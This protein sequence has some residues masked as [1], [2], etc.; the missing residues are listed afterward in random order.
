V[1]ASLKGHLLVASPSLIDPHFVRTVVLILEHNSTEGAVGVVLNRPSTVW[2]DGALPEWD[3]FAATPSVVFVGG[4]VGAGGAIC[5]GRKRGS[6]ELDVLDLSREPDDQAPEQVRLFSG[7]AGWGPGQIEEE[8]AEGAWFVLS[9]GP[10]DVLSED[11][12]GLWGR[13]LRRQSGRV[14]IYATYPPA[15]SLN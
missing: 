15:L 3:S 14:Q 11:P 4:P 5:L 12:E 9:A 7:Y 6:I 1:A 10:D 8:I 13:V 2:V